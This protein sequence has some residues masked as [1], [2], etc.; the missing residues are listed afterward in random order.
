MNPFASV[1]TWGFWV[2]LAAGLWLDEL[3]W[4]SAAIFV[5][6]WIAALGVSWYE[7]PMLFLPFVAL[8]DIVLV[9]MIFKGDVT[10]R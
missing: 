10:L 9:L 4:K 5:V 7:S 3:S 2:L 8:L 6:L 1:A